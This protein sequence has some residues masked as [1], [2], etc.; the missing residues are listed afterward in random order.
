MWEKNDFMW[1]N[2]QICIFLIQKVPSEYTGIKPWL[3]ELRHDPVT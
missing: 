1:E 2:C 3:M